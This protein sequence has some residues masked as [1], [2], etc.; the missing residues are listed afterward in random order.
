MNERLFAI[1]I[2]LPYKTI[3]ELSEIAKSKK[4]TV[5][6]VIQKVVENYVA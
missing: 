6:T 1:I 4:T 2:K 3:M 5:L